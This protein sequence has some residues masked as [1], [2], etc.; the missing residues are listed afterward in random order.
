MQK[1]LL[2]GIALVAG[3]ASGPSDAADL[4]TSM[5]MKAP[6][7][8]PI[9]TWTGCYIGANAGGGE[10]RDSFTDVDPRLALS[11]RP[12]I[13]LGSERATGAMGGGQI[14]CDYQAGNWVVGAQGMFDATD[15]KGRNH[16]VPG[17]SDPQF[18]DIYDLSS[19]ASW[20]ATATARVG[21]VALPQLLVYAKGGAAWVRSDL[22]YSITAMGLTNTYTGAET[23]TGWT[24]GAGLEYLIA[25]NWS[26]FAE[27]S[28][29]DFGSGTLDTTLSTN[30]SPV[31]VR[32]G[33]RI[34]S[35]MLGLN[36]R[37]GSP[38]R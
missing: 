9:Y 20:V 15:F 29:M 19:R 1:L 2:L 5:S 35:V 23:R 34:D 7:M 36:Y 6:A 25:T 17:P 4:R 37:V 3:I 12:N 21:Y 28:H 27:Y 13:D 26:V 18:G 32:I 14:G 16:V 24:A 38:G 30:P 8:A 10:H 11:S 22:N 31:P 33:H